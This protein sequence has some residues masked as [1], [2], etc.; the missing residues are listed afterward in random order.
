[1]SIYEA[2]GIGWVIFTACLGHVAI[3]WLALSGGNRIKQRLEVGQV[4][5]AAAIRDYQAVNSLRIERS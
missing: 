1:M 5:E 2:I 3:A 4:A